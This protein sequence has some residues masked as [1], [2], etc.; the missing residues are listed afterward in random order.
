MKKIGALGGS[1]IVLGTVVLIIYGVIYLGKHF[2]LNE[3][4]RLYDNYDSITYINVDYEKEKVTFRTS[5]FWAME[6][7]EITV[8]YDWLANSELIVIDN[9]VNAPTMIDNI[10]AYS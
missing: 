5:D 7:T 4:N 3:A 10:F 6:K 8:G 1:L 2:I 9:S